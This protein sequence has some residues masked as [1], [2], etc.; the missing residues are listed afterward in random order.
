M[1]PR[2]NSQFVAASLTEFLTVWSMAGDANLNLTTKGGNLNLQFSLSLGTPGAPFSPC[3]P[4]PP[5]FKARHRGPTQRECDRQRAARHQAAKSTSPAESSV[6]STDPVVGS[7]T[8][9]DIIPVTASVTASDNS[10]TLSMTGF[11]KVAAS[12]SDDS[13]ITTA[14]VATDRLHFKC[15]EC[16]LSFESEHGLRIHIG[17]QHKN[18]R[19]TEHIRKE[20]FDN[21]LDLSPRNHPKL[22]SPKSWHLHIQNGPIARAFWNPNQSIEQKVKKLVI[23]KV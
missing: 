20:S 11:E 16:E 12:E 17:K 1:T 14:S 7:P 2:T 4:T 19:K 13:T 22:L 10:N 15:E 8:S 18:T 6:S 21:S 5:P 3:S 9:A 23:R